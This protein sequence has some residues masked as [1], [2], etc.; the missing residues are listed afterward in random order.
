MPS[1]ATPRR[2]SRAALAALAVLAVAVLLA[3]IA[4]HDRRVWL[5][6]NVLV[7]FLAGWL[8]LTAR[9]F[10]LSP[11]SYGLVLAFLLLHEIGA[12]FTYPRVP[13]E[14]AIAAW[15]G[16]SVDRLLGF[17]RNHWD[18]VVHLAFGLA[19]AWPLREVARRLAGVRGFW[20]LAVP[21][22]LVMAI[23]LVYEFIE[24]GVAVRMGVGPASAFLGAQGDP[25]DAHHDLL[26]ASLG[27]LATVALAALADAVRDPRAFVR[28]WRE[29]V[30]VKAP[31]GG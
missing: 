29:S 15:T 14:R 30:R 28:D 10:P 22:A 31:P 2:P 1:P 17:D 8:A 24:W 6:E 23:G 26:L 18:R 25:W 27:A 7:V 21:V 13:Y 11:I 5:A 9:S 12:H 3:G 20:A 19:F 16:V 4:P